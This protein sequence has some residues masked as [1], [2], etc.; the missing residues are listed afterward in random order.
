MSAVTSL[1]L[2]SLLM[3]CS[4]TA[5]TSCASSQEKTWGYALGTSTFLPGIV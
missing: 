4:H 2:G 3:L 1:A 5:A